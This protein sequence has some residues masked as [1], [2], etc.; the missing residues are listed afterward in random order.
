MSKKPFTYSERDSKGRLY[1]DCTECQKGFNGY[2]SCASG[3]R[4]QK[5]H[6]GGCFNGTLLTCYEDRP[7]ESK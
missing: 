4:I 7:N 1:V 5:G 6:T 2:K 3:H